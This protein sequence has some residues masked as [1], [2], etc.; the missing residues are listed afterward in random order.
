MATATTTTAVQARPDRWWFPL[1]EGILAILL[2]LM[3][4]SSPAVTSVAFV[5]GLGLFW[6]VVGIIDIVRLFSD[7]TFWGWK[8]FTGIL[9]ILTGALVVSGILGQNHPLGTAFAVGSAFTL[10]L[11]L[12]TI[13]YG[14]AGL[15]AAF[16]GNGWWPGVLGGFGIV[17]GLMMLFNPWA[18]TLA[19]PWSLGIVLIAGGIFLIIAAFRM[20]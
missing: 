2:G 16:R 18:A 6:F 4:L 1:V 11:S 7:R 19:L 13:A 12:F 9:G 8:L 10:I 15:I 14:V 3:F 20:R 17:F 5:L